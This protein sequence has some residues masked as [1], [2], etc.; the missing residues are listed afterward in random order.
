M[1]PVIPSHVVVVPEIIRHGGVSMNVSVPEVV[2]ASVYVVS[3]LAVKLP[4]TWRVPVTAGAGQ[5]RPASARSRLP[6]TRR[7]DEVTVQ[8]PATSPPQAETLEQEP[9]APPLPEPLPPVPAPVPPPVPDG[10][11]EPPE[12]HAPRIIPIA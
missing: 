1:G 9:L 7:H 12:L 10:A 2:V 11:P 3:P 4:V 6:L 8:V 5:F